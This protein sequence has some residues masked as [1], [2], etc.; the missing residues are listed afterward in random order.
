MSALHLLA[1]SHL[2]FPMDQTIAGDLGKSCLEVEALVLSPSAG[3]GHLNLGMD[4][5]TVRSQKG[6]K[7]EGD[8]NAVAPHIVLGRHMMLFPGPSIAAPGSC[9]PNANQGLFF[10]LLDWKLRDGKVQRSAWLPSVFTVHPANAA[11]IY[12]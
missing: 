7:E 5:I 11:S 4:S 2:S 1:V 6:F 12:S 10:C 8:L 3:T 9:S